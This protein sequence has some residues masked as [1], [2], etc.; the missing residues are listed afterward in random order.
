[1]SNGAGRS[2]KNEPNDANHVNAETKAY[3]RQMSEKNNQEHNDGSKYKGK[4]Q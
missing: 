3:Q 4:V 2:K 1:M